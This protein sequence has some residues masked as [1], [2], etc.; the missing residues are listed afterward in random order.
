MSLSLEQLRAAFK[1][2]DSEKQPRQNNY[3]PFWDMPDGAQAVIRFLPDANPENPKGFVVEKHMHTLTINGENKSIPCLKMYGEEC[4]ICKVSSAYYKEGDKV[5]GKKFYRKVQN[6]AQVLVMED[7]LPPNADTNETHEGKI[8]FVALGYQLFQIIK[9]A[10]E[11]GDLDEIPFAYEGGTNFI[12]KKTKQG[13]YPSYSLS[14]FARK[15][16]DLTD[17]ELAI[18]QEGLIDLSTLLP[19]NPGLA[20]VEAMLEAALTGEEY[21]EDDKS[22]TKTTAKPAPTKSK[23]VTE[24]EEDDLVDD[25]HVVKTKPAK[26]AAKPEPKDDEGFDDEADA[27][28]QQIRARQAKKAE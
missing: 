10:F 17:D 19:A 14:K 9:D 4:P 13:D 24:D 28:L 20:K 5:N 2:D 15:S 3:Y 27:I 22:S 16:T 25:T 1:K 26:A 6:L 11:S 21:V 8:R 12:V 18:A 23:V 7:P